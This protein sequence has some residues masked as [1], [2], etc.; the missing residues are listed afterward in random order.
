[1]LSFSRIIC[2]RREP[3]H[4]KL[5]ATPLLFSTLLIPIYSIL[6]SMTTILLLTTLLNHPLV[7]EHSEMVNIAGRLAEFR[8]KQVEEDSLEISRELMIQS[9]D[10]T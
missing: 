1:M 6:N 5:Q 8:K 2:A 9:V 3:K 7:K 10:R 4:S